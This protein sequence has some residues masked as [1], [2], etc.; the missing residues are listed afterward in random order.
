MALH[1]GFRNYFSTFSCRI[2]SEI[3][4]YSYIILHAQ[5]VWDL[6]TDFQ[7]YSSLWYVNVFHLDNQQNVSFDQESPNLCLIY[8]IHRE[9]PS[10]WG[11]EISSGQGPREVKTS[12]HLS[13]KPLVDHISFDS[14]DLSREAV[15]ITCLFFIFM[16][17]T[18]HMIVAFWLKQTS[19]STTPCFRCSTGGLSEW[20]EWEDCILQNHGVLQP[21]QLQLAGQNQQL[22][23]V[24]CRCY[25]I[26]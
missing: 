6:P 18:L 1:L 15:S 16:K 4:K 5:H 23:I 26:H 22:A 2:L 17:H 13:D 3:Q 14:G 9:Q 24:H 12:W 10:S 20:R 25:L 21:G 11:V 19:L 7:W 8:S